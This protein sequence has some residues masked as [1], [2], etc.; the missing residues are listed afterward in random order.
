MTNY[1]LLED[2]FTEIIALVPELADRELLEYLHSYGVKV[3][4]G[5]SVSSDL[6]GIDGTTHTFNAMSGITHRGSS[7]ALSANKMITLFTEVIR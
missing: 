6:T 2:D 1:K 5:H 4:A 7:T 3:Q